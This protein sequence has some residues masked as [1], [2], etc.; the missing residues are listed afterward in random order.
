M[1]WL[2]WERFRCNTDCAQ[3]PA[4]CISER[5]FVETAD[6][7]I[8]GGFQSAGYNYV[9]IDDCWLA[10]ERDVHGKLQPDPHRFPRGMPAIA[11]YLHERELKFGIYGDIGTKTCGGYPGMAGHL[12][13]DAQTYAD[14]GVDYLKVDGCYAD[15]DS[16]NK[17]YPA[18]GA[19]LN[20]TGRPIVYSC[21]WPA[22]LPDPVQ[23]G[24]QIPYEA[25]RRH[26]NLWRN[27]VDIQSDWASLKSIIVFWA[28]AS[29]LSEGF[30]DVAG[31]G[32]FNDPDMLIIGNE[33]ITD[34]QA[35]L[36]MGAWAMFAAPLLMGND[37]RNLTVAQQAILL[38]RDVIA[39]NQ[40]P[41]GHQGALVKCRGSC[42]EGQIW[43]RRLYNGDLAVAFF[44]LNDAA[45]ERICVDWNELALGEYTQRKGMEVFTG[46]VRHNL[47]GE[48]CEELAG[49]SIKLWRLAAVDAVKHAAAVF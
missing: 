15:P 43:Q 12:G 5:L 21:S 37:V 33:G 44:N 25:L 23:T 41:V 13:R 17:T 49:T 6:S 3:D 4:N 20:A 39:I 48:L 31:P 27:W 24:F 28:K 10:K 34:D 7:L 1:G 8:L 35:A 29:L 19:A 2:S 22:Y 18:L 26:C 47:G 9:I 46:T 38:N 32:A 14:W 16:Y 42:E 45:T 11:R 36:Q 30:T 40:D